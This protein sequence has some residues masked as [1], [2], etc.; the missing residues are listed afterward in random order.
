MKTVQK[1][2]P[3][4]RVGSAYLFVFIGI[5]CASDETL[6]DLLPT[7]KNVAAAFGAQP[8]NMPEGAS[9]LDE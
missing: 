9:L 2:D 7:L 3:K 8:E 4:T 5:E 1:L 6:G